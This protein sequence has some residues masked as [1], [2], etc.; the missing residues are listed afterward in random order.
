VPQRDEVSDRG[1]PVN[2]IVWNE[3]LHQSVLSGYVL[4]IDL[5]LYRRLRKRPLHAVY[6][7][8]STRSSEQRGR[9]QWS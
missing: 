2:Y 4:A 5:D 8:S 3:H 7:R 9:G 6:T 1:S